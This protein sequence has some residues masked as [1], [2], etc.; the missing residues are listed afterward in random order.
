MG[1]IEQ[2]GDCHLEDYGLKVRHIL[3]KETHKVV[4]KSTTAN[5]PKMWRAVGM[6]HRVP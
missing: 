5:D 1:R 6:P 4:S 2:N 3:T